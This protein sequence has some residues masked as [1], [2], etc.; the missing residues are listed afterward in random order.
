MVITSSSGGRWDKE[1]KSHQAQ[2]TDDVRTDP[3]HDAT[4]KPP[5]GTAAAADWLLG[6]VIA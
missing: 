4:V 3:H 2:H 6:N 5:L 1:K